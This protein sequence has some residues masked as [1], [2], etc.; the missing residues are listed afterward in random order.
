MRTY[1]WIILF[2]SYRI[3]ANYLIE[4]NV[5]LIANKEFKKSLQ[6]VRGDGKGIELVSGETV[7]ADLREG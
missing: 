5:I 1:F 2:T 7:P 3:T 4:P 6:V